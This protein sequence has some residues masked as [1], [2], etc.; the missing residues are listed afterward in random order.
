MCQW[1]GSSVIGEKLRRIVISDLCPDSY[2]ERFK[3]GFSL[4][5]FPPLHLWRGVTSGAS[6]GEDNCLQFL[7]NP[8]HRQGIQLTVCE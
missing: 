2:R 1:G 6:R 3:N 5:H 8:H 4:T 7:Q